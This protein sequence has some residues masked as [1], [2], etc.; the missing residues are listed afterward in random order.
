MLIRCPECNNEVSDKAEICPHCGIKISGNPEITKT[1]TNQ[2]N[3]QTTRQPNTQTTKQPNGK[4]NAVWVMSLIIAMIVFGVGFYFYQTA[5]EDKEQDAFEYALRSN[6]VMVM[7]NYLSKYQDAPREHRDSIN[8]IIDM[9]KYEDQEWYNAVNS[10]SKKMLQQ[11]IDENQT[12]PHLS[13]A[14]NKI[15]SIDYNHAMREYKSSKNIQ[16]LKNYLQ[17][18]PNGRFASSVQDIMDELK[19]VEVTPEEKDMAKGVLRK[20][21]QAINAKDEKKLLATVT[22]ILDSFLNRPGATNADVVTFMN[23]LY[24]DDI[25]NLNWHMMDNIKAE[26]V[27][28]GSGTKNIRV[29]FGA[30]LHIDRTDP[31]KEKLAK[32]IITADVTPEGLIS[33]YNMKKVAIAE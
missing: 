30:E 21:L 3:A 15:D 1:L 18:H 13:E 12:S 24:K 6:D 11:Y 4:S 7:Q 22:E 19:S 31:N 2:P 10:G 33:S 27:D 26:K 5:Q 32:Y 8:D 20:F 17:E 9:I 25:T 29:Q 23:K 28:N 14:R 16:A